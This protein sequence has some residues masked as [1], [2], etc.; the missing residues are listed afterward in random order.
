MLGSIWIACRR[1]LHAIGLSN[2]CNTMMF[3]VNNAQRVTKLKA[4]CLRQ[5]TSAFLMPSWHIRWLQAR[6][7]V[8]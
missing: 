4:Y 1:I 5:A 3:E 8:L 7:I 2:W 6:D